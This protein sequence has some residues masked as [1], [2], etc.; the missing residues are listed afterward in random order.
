MACL[1]ALLR[2]CTVNMSVDDCKDLASTVSVIS[3]DKLKAERDKDKK[4]TK[5][6]KGK[7]NIAASKASDMDDIGGGGG[8]GWTGGGGVGDDDYGARLLLVSSPPPAARTPLRGTV[9]DLTSV[10]PLPVRRLHV[11]VPM[12]PLSRIWPYLRARVFLGVLMDHV[13]GRLAAQ[14]RRNVPDLSGSSLMCAMSGA[15]YE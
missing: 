6:K 5:G 13:R 12:R 4:K 2:E 1:K 14:L 3:N 15:R 8:P 7:L 11:K 9:F 10:A